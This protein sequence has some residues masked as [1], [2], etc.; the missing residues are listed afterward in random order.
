MEIKCSSCNVVPT[1]DVY[2]TIQAIKFI[3]KDKDNKNISH[4]GLFSIN[5]FYKYFIKNKDVEK[6]I[7]NYIKEI[8]SNYKNKNNINDIPAISNFIKFTKEFDELL[9]MLNKTYENFKYYFYKILYIKKLIYNETEKSNKKEDI[10]YSHIDIINKMK[11][12]INYFNNKILIKEEYPK[13]LNNEEINKKIDK[14]IK[15]EGNKNYFDLNEIKKDFEY[16]NL[17]KNNIAIKKIIKFD[18][19]KCHNEFLIKLNKEL[20]PASILYVYQIKTIMNEFSTCFKIFDKKLNLIMT[21]FISMEKILK[22][23]QLKDNNILLIFKNIIKIIKININNSNINIIQE[24]NSSSKNFIEILINNGEESLLLPTNENYYFYKK[25]NKIETLYEYSFYKLTTKIKGEELFLI[26]NSNFIS[27]FRKVIR[28]YEIIYKFSNQSPTNEIDI[29]KT[30]RISISYSFL[31]GIQFIGENKQ[32]IIISG[33]NLL[34]LLSC[35]YKEIVT[36]ISYN[37]IGSIFKGFNNE[38]YLCLSDWISSHKIIRQININKEG[39][40]IMEGNNYFE[41]IDLYNKYGLI[42]LGDNI[43]YLEDKIND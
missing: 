33:T 6:Y 29:K 26:D 39:I 1:V 31:S 16:K 24:I 5:N 14:I 13:I 15:F 34:F 32:N 2:D 9:I 18:N 17:N 10:Y 35:K 23:I 38:C 41:K 22:I 21:E 3:C 37:S 12:A 20:S 7:N 43:Y 19:I 25:N 4:Y 30:K 11:E 36:I 28:F 8:E 27:L 40:L 42:D